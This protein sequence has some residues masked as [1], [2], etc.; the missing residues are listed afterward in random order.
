MLAAVLGLD[1]QMGQFL[2]FSKQ[3][4]IFIRTLRLMRDD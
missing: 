4:P 1:R 3:L 2:V